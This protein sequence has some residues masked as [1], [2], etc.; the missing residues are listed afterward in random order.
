MSVELTINVRTPLTDDDKALLSPFGV[1]MLT[2]ANPN[3]PREAFPDEPPPPPR[4]ASFNSD[5]EVCVNEPGHAGPH[6]YQPLD[7][8][9]ADVAEDE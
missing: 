5:R 2:I 7:D 8:V 1:V 3:T 6:A 9:I 4:C